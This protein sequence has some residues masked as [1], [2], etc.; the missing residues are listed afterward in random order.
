MNIPD[1]SALYIESALEKAVSYGGEY[2]S[3]IEDVLLLHLCGQ[4]VHSQ[5]GLGLLGWV[6]RQSRDSTL[7]TVKVSDAGVPLVA[8]VTSATPTG[9]VEMY[10]R[11]FEADRLKWMRDKYP[12][13]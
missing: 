9:C 10:W 1:E 5:N 4:N 2:S 7:L 6:F 3:G 11:Q 8:F 13:I 12:W